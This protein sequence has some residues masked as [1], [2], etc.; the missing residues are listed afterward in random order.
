VK[1]PQG[2]STSCFFVFMIFPFFLSTLLPRDVTRFWFFLDA[3]TIFFDAVIGVPPPTISEQDPSELFLVPFTLSRGIIV[4]GRGEISSFRNAILKD[5][6][7]FPLLLCIFLLR[8][9]NPSFFLG[10]LL[11]LRST[12]VP[13]REPENSTNPWSATPLISIMSRIRL[14]SLRSV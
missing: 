2:G 12:D 14:M 3:L 11:S 9:G 8:I 7:T 4:R 1:F 13:Y 6:P 10:R 5:A